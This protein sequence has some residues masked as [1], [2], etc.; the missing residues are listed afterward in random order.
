MEY[1]EYTEIIFYFSVDFKLS[2]QNNDV[3]TGC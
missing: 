1:I 3:E 2:E